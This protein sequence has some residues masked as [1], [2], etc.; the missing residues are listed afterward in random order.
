MAI[1]ILIILNWNCTTCQGY[2]YHNVRIYH[3]C[4]SA[5]TVCDT[6][7]IAEFFILLC[8]LVAS[9]NSARRFVCLNTYEKVLFDRTMHVVSFFLF[10]L[11]IYLVLSELSLSH[12]EIHEM[13]H[14]LSHL[15]GMKR[16]WLDQTGLFDIN[17]MGQGVEL[18]NR[19][20]CIG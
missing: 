17:E 9:S 5:I 18:I 13:I 16:I 12:H 2:S 3:S 7:L 20:S 1:V 10:C 11:P 15:L 6:L 8:R 14:Q 4:N 19:P